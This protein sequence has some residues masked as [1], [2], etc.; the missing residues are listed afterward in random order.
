LHDK[1]IFSTLAY[2]S[3]VCCM[4]GMCGFLFCDDHQFIGVSRC[5]KHPWSTGGD[6]STA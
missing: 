2:P 6:G 4:F 5:E 1:T 3:V